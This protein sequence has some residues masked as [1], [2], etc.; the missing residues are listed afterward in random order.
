MKIL[1]LTRYEDMGASSR[2]RFYQFL[3]YLESQGISV[4]CYPLL[5][6]SYLQVLYATGR[7]S[8]SRVVRGYL[9]RVKALVKINR[10]DLCWVEKELLPWVPALEE[11]FLSRLLKPYVVDYDDAVFHLYD[12]H[13]S[14]AVRFLVGR[15]LDSVM[16]NAATVTAGNDYLADRARSAGAGHVQVLP[17]VVDASRYQVKTHGPGSFTVGWVGT[18]VTEKYLEIVKRPFALLKDEID[19][20]IALNGAS[21]RALAD[22]HPEIL[23]WTAETEVDVIRSFDV[24][25]MPLRDDAFERG[26]CGYKLI[27]YMA[28]GIPVIASPVGVNATIVDHGVNGFLA[29]SE[30]EWVQY[31]DLLYRDDARRKEMGVRARIKIEQEYS[32][33][34]VAPKLCNIL[35][36]AADSQNGKV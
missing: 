17:T 26:K 14:K 10:F 33:A 30:K 32:L 1:A 24:G 35:A 13:S 3:P 2:L 12:K 7:R 21:P 5:A 19:L 25:I 9:K 20:K 36:S 34:G 4:H 23:T 6:N 15:K 16:R 8:L 11:L 18:P 22:L 29:E 28:C 31:L 27:Q